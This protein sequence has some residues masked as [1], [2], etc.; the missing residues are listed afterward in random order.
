MLTTFERELID[1]IRQVAN[2]D[3]ATQRERAICLMLCDAYELHG[4]VHAAE[5]VVAMDAWRKRAGI[6]KHYTVS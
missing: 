1:E 2:S 6:L 5:I 4:L 3:A